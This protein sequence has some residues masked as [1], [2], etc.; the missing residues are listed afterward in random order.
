MSA[1]ALA[2][3]LLIVWALARTPPPAID[4]EQKP[5]VA[6]LVR[7]GEKRP[8][9]WLP[10]KEAAPPPPAPAP[11][12]RRRRWSPPPPRRAAAERRA[13]G[14]AAPG[15]ARAAAARRARRA[16]G[17]EPRVGPLEGAARRRT[18]AAG[19]IPPATP[20]ATPRPARATSYLALVAPRAPRELHVPAT[21]PE[22][23]RLYLKAT[24]VLWIEPD[25]RIRRWRFRSAP[26][27]TPPSTPRWSAR[28]SDARVPPPPDRMR[29]ALPPRTASRSI[30]QAR[31]T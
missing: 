11:P 29:D 24:V 19:A 5:I 20:P 13:R 7:L 9:Q 17:D 4:L 26:R 22:R 15:R 18:S 16:P 10:R 23:E 30:F 2:H 31:Q 14:E 28:S 1:S 27:G 3:V 25:G 6:K 21:I 8:E 12:R